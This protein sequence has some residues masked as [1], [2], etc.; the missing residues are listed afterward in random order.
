MSTPGAYKEESISELA[1]IDCKCVKPCPFCFNAAEVWRSDV[2]CDELQ[3]KDT[4]SDEIARGGVITDRRFLL[5]TSGEVLFDL[6]LRA[7]EE[8]M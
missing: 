3:G 2:V 1:G 4:G 8:R 6:P 5:G 7:I